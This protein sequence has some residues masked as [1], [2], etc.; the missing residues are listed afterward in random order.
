MANEKLFYIG[1]KG[2]I[3]DK[4][5]RILLLKADV[6][7]H[8]KNKEPYW[9]IPGG[10]ISEEQTVIQTLK[11]EIEEETGITKLEGHEFFTAVVSNHEIPVDDRLL[12]LALMIYKVK[13]PQGSKVSLSEEHVAYEWV[14]RA[15]AKKRLAHKY[16][17]EFTDQL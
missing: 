16:P 8:R 10:R 17:P 7:K 11:R 15:E 13:V 6:N 5:G 4:E 14:D 1:V 2:L 9:D 12:G 3:E